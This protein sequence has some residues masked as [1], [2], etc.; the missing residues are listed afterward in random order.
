MADGSSFDRSFQDGLLQQL[1]EAKDVPTFETRWSALCSSLQS[2]FRR[3]AGSS[4]AVIDVYS[5]MEELLLANTQLWPKLVAPVLLGVQQGVGEGQNSSAEEMFSIITSSVQ[6]SA[7]QQAVRQELRQHAAQ[8]LAAVQ[9][10]AERREA[11]AAATFWKADFR[12]S[13]LWLLWEPDFPRPFAGAAPEGIT[14][15]LGCDLARQVD[16]PPGCS[17]RWLPGSSQLMHQPQLLDCMLALAGCSG[18]TSFAR[19]FVKRIL[20][21]QGDAALL[22]TLQRMRRV[23][24]AA[25]AYLQALE[26]AVRKLQSG[27][28]FG[29]PPGYGHTMQLLQ[30]MKPMSG[31]RRGLMALAPHTQLLSRVAAVLQFTPADWEAKWFEDGTE[32]SAQK[33]AACKKWLEETAAAAATASRETKEQYPEARRKM[34]DALVN[35]VAPVYAELRGSGEQQQ[36]VQH[37]FVTAAVEAGVLASCVAEHEELLQLAGVVPDA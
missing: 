16:L 21:A 12:Y 37:K 34:M 20:D 15:G 33:V 32:L 17:L 14:S 13:L 7:E 8:V 1:A 11:A 28:R 29:A 30:W 5:N 10:S 27:E 23:A 2:R 3:T 31:S 25:E 26:P 4:A 9:A 19:P 22:A 6:D 35:E 18:Y 24:V 36:D